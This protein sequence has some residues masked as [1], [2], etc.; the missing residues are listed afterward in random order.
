MRLH[1]FKDGVKVVRVHLDKLPLLELG[2]RLLRVTGEV[3]Q[4]SDHEG[5][6]L[7][8]N[9]APNFDVIGDLAPG[10]DAPG[11]ICAVRFV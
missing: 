3:S 2:K 11:P 1:S 10:E 4:D 5:E 6:F 8:L 7:E 9:G